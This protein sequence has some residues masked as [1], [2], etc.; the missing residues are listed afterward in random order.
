[1]KI[2]KFSDLQISRNGEIE[3]VMVKII[4]EISSQILIK[5]VCLR[6]IEKID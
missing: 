2:E 3:F 4:D 6:L 1:M 5:F